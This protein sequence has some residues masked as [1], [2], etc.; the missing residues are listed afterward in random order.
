[1][2]EEVNPLERD[3]SVSVVLPGGLEKNATVHGSKPV[4]DLLV[5]LCA[6][7][8]LNPSDYT[9]EVL[10]PNKNNIS[11]KPNSPIG[12]LEA[13][14]IVLKPKGAEEKPKQ[15]YMP[16]ATVRLLIN[17]NKS[18]KAVVRVNPRIPLEFLLPQVCDKCEFNVETT[19]LLTYSHS[20][21]PLDMTKTLNDYGLREVF[22]KDTARKEPQQRPSVSE[23]ADTPTKVISPPPVEEL[24]KKEKTTTRGFLSLF[25]RQK[26]KSEM[27]GA[28]SAPTSPDLN[29]QTSGSLNTLSGPSSNTL[30]ADMP[31][32][33]RAP[34]PPIGASQSIPNSLG[35]CHLR[36]PQVGRTII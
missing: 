14:K 30:P 6:S 16:E 18:H 23:S 27:D 36:T 8:H 24:P 20:K 35:T 19:I 29:K 1:M 12:S 15:P 2:D 25:R 7:Y 21:E 33:R 28:V 10:S 3:H 13:D 34:Q 17:Y 9:V 26:K 31:K 5:T 11:F 4:M 32:K 22:A